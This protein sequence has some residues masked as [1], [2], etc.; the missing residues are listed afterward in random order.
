MADELCRRS[1]ICLEN[2]FLADLSFLQSSTMSACIS[3]NFSQKRTVLYAEVL[4][5]LAKGVFSHK[6]V[7]HFHIY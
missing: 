6:T 5:Y 1:S 4:Y 3:L 2:D 7:H